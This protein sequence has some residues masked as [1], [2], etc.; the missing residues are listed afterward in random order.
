MGLS[1]MI[2]VCLSSGSDVVPTSR[3]GTEPNSPWKVGMKGK[4]T[5]EMTASLVF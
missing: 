2:A 3:T 4:E 5:G 1:V